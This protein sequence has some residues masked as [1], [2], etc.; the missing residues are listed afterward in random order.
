[1]PVTR[2][3]SLVSLR[4]KSYWFEFEQGPSYLSCCLSLSVSVSLSLSFSSL[5]LSN[6][7]PY[8]VVSFGRYSQTSRV[9]QESLCPTWDQTLIFD[10]IRL[11]GDLK[12]VKNFPPQ[13]VIELYDKDQ[14]VRKLL[15]ML[16]CHL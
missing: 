3:G 15:K 2:M 9:V 4:S 12:M 6:I 8:A 14:V 7:D 11:F 5:S 16:E 1:M 10:G 13:I